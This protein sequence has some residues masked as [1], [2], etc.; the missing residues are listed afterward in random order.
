[1]RNPDLGPYKASSVGHKLSSVEHEERTGIWKS[2]D[3]KNWPD[4]PVRQKDVQS[5]I[6][7]TSMQ[8][9]ISCVFNM[10]F[11]VFFLVRVASTGR[12]VYGVGST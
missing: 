12:T 5:F 8:T 1:M 11:F 2:F 9:Q 4:A 10:L 6:D 7:S 3:A